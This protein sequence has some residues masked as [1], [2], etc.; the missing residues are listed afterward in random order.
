[1]IKPTVQSLRTDPKRRLKRLALGVYRL[2][3]ILLAL[4][5]L[6]GMPRD[7]T[8]LNPEQLLPIARESI[9]GVVSV[10]DPKDGL[11]PLLDE[12]EQIM[13]WATS[14]L[15]EAGKIQGYSGPSELLVILDA[16]RKV[17]AVRFLSSADTDGH[18]EKVLRDGKF[19]SQWD[20]MPESTLGKKASPVVVSGATLTSEAMARGIAARF[21]AEGMEQWFPASLKL[22]DVKKWF[23]QADRIGSAEV[24]GTYQIFK[25]DQSLGTVLRSSRMGVSAR[26][27][28]GTSDVIVA[29]DEYGEKVLGIGFLGSR[30]N[31][32]YVSDVRDEVKYSDGFAGKTVNEILGEDPKSS[33]SLFT[34]GA[35]YTNSAVVES[36]REMLTRHIA[37]TKK[38]TFPWK[39]ALAVLWIA[40]GVFVGL[41]KFGSKRVVRLSFA[42]VSVAA[43]LWLG[44]LVSQ[45]QLIGWGSHGLGM[46]VMMPLI[47]LTAAAL[48]VPAFTGKNVYCNRICPHGAAQTLAGEFLRKRF[49][50]PAKLHMVLVRLPWVTL[51]AIW[52]LAFLASGIPFA[53]FEPFETWSTGFIAFIPSAIFTI[54]LVAAFFLP[55][56]YCHYGCPTGAMLRFLTQSPSAWTR[57]DTIAG[58]LILAASLYVFL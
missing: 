37:D 45:D 11:F 53:Y 56:A 18:V 49:H 15:P 48:M 58:V 14:T 47:V 39:Q 40:V 10:G 46:G 57:R 19:W 36:V 55:Q 44:W 31:E 32:P 4:V 20:G 13:G 16:D 8:G 2:G 6:G 5:C 54:G 24:S 38:N 51:L 27:F 35:S 3:I 43:G 26:G 33:P 25:G 28:N 29:L 17:K 21:G 7:E 9:P 50:L 42:V 34:S 23:P 41:S 1:M 52:L 12:A 22:D 30:D